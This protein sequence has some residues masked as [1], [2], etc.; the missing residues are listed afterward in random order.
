M[1]K[2]EVKRIFSRVGLANKLIYFLSGGPLSQNQ[3]IDKLAGIGYFW[4]N[5]ASAKRAIRLARAEINANLNGDTLVGC[6]ENGM[7]LIKDKVTFESYITE[8]QIHLEGVARQISVAKD[9]YARIYGPEQLKFFEEGG[10][11][12]GEESEKYKA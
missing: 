2:V 12:N 1:D 7:F 4:K 11:N 10:K 9:K 3:I 5:R 8:M 6:D